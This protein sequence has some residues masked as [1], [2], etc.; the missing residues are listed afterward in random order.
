MLRQDG[1]MNHPQFIYKIVDKDVWDA[2]R[3]EGVFKGVEIDLKDKFIHFSSE[4]QVKETAQKHFA[5]VSNL[6]VAKID[7]SKLGDALKW[8]IS[9]NGDLFPHLYSALSFE[10]VVSQ[11]D[12]K[13]FLG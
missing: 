1:L 7:G 6:V 13:T 9:R 8:E 11:T 12:L 4:E 10:A 2:A 5:G 3:K